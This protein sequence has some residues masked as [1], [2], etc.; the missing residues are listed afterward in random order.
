MIYKRI[1]SF[2]FF[3]IIISGSIFSQGRFKSFSGDMDDY[4]NEL[5]EFYKSDVN[6]KKDAQ[7]EYEELIIKY[8]EVWNSLPLQQKKDVINLS[9]QMLAKRVRP[10][11]GFYE[12]IQTQLGFAKYNYTPENFNQW[13]KGM[14]WILKNSTIGNFNNAITSSNN[15]I[16]NNSLYTSRTINWSFKNGNFTI[17]IDTLK[18]VYADFSQIDLTYSSQKDFNTIYETK[19]RFYIADQIFEG[20]G[21]KIDWT[22]AELPKDMVYAE[23]S[24]YIVSLKRAAISA[25]SVKFTNKEY[26]Q[27]KLIGRLEDVC[28]D[29]V[30]EA[31]FPKFTSYKREEIIKNVFPNVDYVGGFTQQGGKFL[32]TGDAVEPASLVF[33]KDDKVFCRAKAIVHPF[34]R[35]GITTK[36]CQITFYINSDSIYHPGILMKYNKSSQEIACIDNREGI[37]ASPW[38]DS[39]HSIDIYTEAVYTNINSKEFE[40]GSIKSPTNAVSFASFE[41]NNYYTLAKWEKLQG[42]NDINPLYRIKAFTDRFNKQNIPVK[43]FSRFLNVDEAQA[44]VLLMN[45]AINGFI[46]YEAYRKM[47][48]VKPKLYDYILANNKKKDYDNIRLVSSVKGGVNAVLD[49]ETMD[50]KLNGIE[51]FALSEKHFVNIAPING[52][53][54]MKKNRSFAFDGRLLAGRVNLGGRDCFFDY[55]NFKLTLPAIDSLAFYVPLYE[56]TTKLVNVQ[57]PIHNLNVEILI[58]APNNKSSI[59]D[60]PGYPVLSSLKDSYVYYDNPKI[61]NGVYSREKFYYQVKP[62]KLTSLMSFKTDSIEFAGSLKSAGIFPD[63]NV[64]LKV[65]RDYSLGFITNTPKSGFDAYGGK[66]KFYNRV[67]L[68]LQGLLGAGSLDYIAS[69]SQSKLYVFMPDSMNAVTDRFI[70]KSTIIGSGEFPDVNNTKTIQRWY[71]YQDYMI[72]G[73]MAEEFTMY[74]TEATHNG[75]LRVSP[76]GLRGNG[77]NKAN[78]MIVESK[79]FNYKQEYFI[80]DTSNFTLKTLNNQEIAFKANGVKSNVNF[81]NRKGD[82][83][84][85]D[86][87]KLCDLTYM[88]Y[89]CYVDKYTWDFDTKELAFLDSQS[90]KDGGMGAKPIRELVDLEQPGVKLTSTNPLQKN[91]SFNSIQP[92][93]SLKDNK[94]TANQ[95]FIIKS[96]DA[97][98][99]PENNRVVIRPGA[100]MDTIEKAEIL[101][102]IETKN[103]LVYN[104]RVSVFSSEFYSANGYIDYA[105]ENKKKHSIFL[106]KI[107]PEQKITKASGVIEKDY[108]LELSSHFNYYGNINIAPKDTNYFFDGYV[109]LTHNCETELAWMKFQSQINPLGIYIPIAKAPISDDGQRITSS[110]LYNEKNLEPKTAFL[111]KDNEVNAFITIDGFLTYNKNY[112]QYVIAS[113]DK[114]ED[115]KNSLMPF[116]SFDKGTCQTTAK[117]KINIGMSNQGVLTTDNYGEIKANNSDQTATMSMS[118]GI[119]FPFSEK[120]LDF[121]GVEIYED[122]NLGAI[123]LENSRY[124]EYLLSK[125]SEKGQDLYDDLLTT[126]EWK[127]IPKEL[128]YTLFFTN[129]NFQWDPVFRSYVSYGDVEIAIIGKYQVNKKIR[130]KI[131]LIKTSISH[132]F[133]IY[134]EQNLN[135]W[136]FF[137]YNGSAMSAISSN[138]IFNDYIK[139]VPNK[140]REFKGSD[141]K[142]FTYRLATPNEKRNFITKLQKIDLENNE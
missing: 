92:L 65:M 44:E 43:E 23:L 131:E 47:A 49:I 109:N 45:L 82:F 20:K 27:Y 24:D 93:L 59:K 132:E 114:H 118:F 99:K 7:K 89:N 28:S 86:G 72:V 40:F 5:T 90:L 137:T 57:T 96:A 125:S 71:P 64:P 98:I 14:D 35:D 141:N 2:A 56:D 53:I 136:Y 100:Q 51:R 112:N 16:N 127:T 120:A 34:S 17:R 69:N 81:K 37:S 1:I 108:P 12:F 22:R 97:G 25:D 18:G 13:F 123:E 139:E 140:D 74:N 58:D 4:I 67:D 76:Y 60:I 66:G 10:L 124:Q 63:I 130:A 133:R 33:K 50:L 62:F 36:D 55:E 32:G 48:F 84:S 117:G 85:L 15:L 46:S 75:Y 68:S 95:V 80:A 122:L 102:D 79:N 42:I 91:L 110:I 87:V 111:T 138:E 78:E 6:M 119:K 142:I 83:T 77:V 116:I 54:L 126:G 11:P 103:H 104:S 38:V 106:N 8:T 101:F 105:D 61:Q 52:E 9:N 135:S 70:T 129:V 19:G 29:K 39:Y 30:G 134:L 73:Q 3:L 26:F 115:M 128:D 94:L 88:Q 21:G 41:S 113:M 107:F 121:M 31:N